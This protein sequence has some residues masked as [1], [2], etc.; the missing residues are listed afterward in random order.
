MLKLQFMQGL[1]ISGNGTDVGKTFVAKY[2]IKLLS[3]DYF[4]RARKPVESCCKKIGKELIPKDSVILNKACKHPEPL[5][6]VCSFRFEDCVSGEKASTDKNVLITLNQLVLACQPPNKNDFV[7]VEGCGGICS[8]IAKN[9]LNSDLIKELKIPLVFVVNDGLGAIN[10]AL[11]CLQ[12]AKQ[13][14]L[15]VNS[16]ILNQIK[17]NKLEN[18]KAIANYTNVDIHEFSVSKIDDFKRNFKVL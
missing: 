7:I 3:K 6:N 8:P 9:V 5:T 10:Q 11:L 12:L 1:F 17:S 13:Q 15:K 4:V 16:L 18:K 14:K 2:L